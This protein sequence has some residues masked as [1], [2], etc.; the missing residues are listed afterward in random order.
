MSGKRTA[1]SAAPS[2]ERPSK[3]TKRSKA[4]AVE[5]PLVV[6]TVTSEKTTKTAAPSAV[7]V[8]GTLGPKKVSPPVNTTKKAK[9]D[10]DV[11]KAIA[12]VKRTD[13]A[14]A[15]SAV[16]SIDAKEA[17]PVVEPPQAYGAT[18]SAPASTVVSAL[19]EATDEPASDDTKA[20]AAV[21]VVADTAA[22]A[23]VAVASDSDSSVSSQSVSASQKVHRMLAPQLSN[24][25]MHL[26]YEQVE[27]M[28]TT[29]IHRYN[30]IARLNVSGNGF[31]R[32]PFTHRPM[33]TKSTPPTKITTL[34]TVQVMY[35]HTYWEQIT[36]MAYAS[37]KEFLMAFDIFR[38]RMR[39]AEGG[40]PS[41]IVSLFPM[42]SAGY[43]ESI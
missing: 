13:V 6:K 27:D 4:S 16:V 21:V 34:T 40:K 43:V 41:T 22:A 25:V 31:T 32:D 37:R 9:A 3:V 18:A 8:K 15:D 42:G 17:E 24:L 7:K 20:T 12:A 30:T 5:E 14:L 11:K 33:A 36:L 26:T 28:I 35:W 19:V 39:L 2:V 38:W 29:L 10:D 23:A 1:T